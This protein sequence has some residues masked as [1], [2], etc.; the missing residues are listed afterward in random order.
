MR[1]GRRFEIV[2]ERS[3]RG[4]SQEDRVARLVALGQALSDPIR[5]RMLGMMG[6]AAL[7]ATC[8]TSTPPRT[9]TIHA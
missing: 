5:V 8:R 1:K 6:R 3:S 9:K 2:E 7:A 4:G